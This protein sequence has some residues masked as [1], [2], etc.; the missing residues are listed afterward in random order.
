MVLISQGF[1]L[2][3]TLTMIDNND[4]NYNILIHQPMTLDKRF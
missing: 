1:T 4:N 2:S 3:E